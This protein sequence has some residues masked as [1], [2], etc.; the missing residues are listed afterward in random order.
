[1]NKSSAEKVPAKVP[2]DVSRNRV[3]RWRRALLLL[4]LALLGIL[5][6]CYLGRFDFCAAMTVFPAW[7]WLIPG[8]LLAGPESWRGSRRWGA[9]GAGLWLAFAVVWADTPMAPV[10][11]FTATVSA[12]GEREPFRP[13]GTLRIVVLNCATRPESAREVTPL[14]PDIV[15]LQESP[16]RQDTEELARQ[17]YGPDAALVWG[18][19]TS[20]L[21]R[22]RIVAAEDSP[23]KGSDFA[24]ARVRL[25]SGAEVEVLSL[26][27]VPPPFS[28]DLW[29][30]ECWSDYA[31]SRRKR[32]AQLQRI[33]AQLDAVAPDVPVIVGGDFN[34]P[35]GD[36]IFRLLR[37]RFADAFWS[38]GIGWGN[39]ITNDRP[40]VRIDQVWTSDH[41]Q[42]IAVFAR[43]TLNSDHRM[44][45][46]DLR[47]K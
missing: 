25:A 23:V 2:S 45:V 42:P 19:D 29:L 38:G 37:P 33:L 47:V 41:F 34:A 16:R 13:G 21:A 36:A 44:V 22:G 3:S 17:L 10:R 18:V 12:E 1:M 15:L 8:L 31:E 46:C 30:P 20:L 26:R 27:L 24:R 28:L 4:S 43:K 7:A 40:V 9:A 32:R 39:T 14:D 5:W 11:S 6:L 35:P